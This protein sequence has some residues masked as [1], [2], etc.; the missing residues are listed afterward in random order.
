MTTPGLIRAREAY[1]RRAWRE[2][3]AAYSEERAAGTFAFTDYEN[4]GTTAHLIGD[5]ELS[6]E[7]LAEGYR[8]GMRRG[9]PTWAARMAFWIGHGLI[10]DGGMSQAAG[11]FARGKQ[12][13]A[14]R[15][16]DCAE[17]G[18]L[19]IPDGVGL[20]ESGEPEAAVQ[21]FRDILALA[22]AVD[23]PQLRTMATFGLG[24]ATLRLGDIEGGMSVL[25]EVIVAISLGEMPAM[26]I[27][28]AYCGVLEA[29]HEVLDLGRARE[30]TGALTAW[31]EEQPDLVPYR[32]PCRVYRAEVL[33][34]DGAWSE[35]F[36][37]A[38]QA[39]DWLQEL[40]T[41]EGPGD[42][43][44]RLGE[45]H[46]LRAGMAAAEEYYRQASRAGRRPEP[47]NSLLLL[48][49][50]KTEQA[51]SSIRRAIREET[52]AAAPRA[53]LLDAALRIADAMGDPEEAHRLADEIQKVAGTQKTVAL[54]GIADRALGLALMLGGEAEAA[55]APL[56]RAW[57]DW[58]R[59]G[60]P[61]EAGYTR[62]LLGRAY[63]SLGDT[64]AAAMEFDAARWVFTEL[65]ALHD[66]AELDRLAGE[67]AGALPTGPL[68][69]R[70]REVLALIAQGRTNKEIGARLVIS[71]HTVARHV[72]NMLGKLGL[73][74]RT[75][76]ATYA[77][78]SGL[79]PARTPQS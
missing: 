8:E 2:A 36:A 29:C 58:Q 24:R 35:A 69:L 42:A 51:V 3:H 34:F 54:R 79:I 19:R 53:L 72:Q 45:I 44:Y 49:Q 40:R 28:D 37:E 78:E 27:G 4:Y 73:A 66:L 64:D 41:P 63:Q 55:I 38:Q 30:W 47:G 65:G 33:Q 12:L 59:L 16:G 7:I 74:S 9:E 32:E 62:V 13:L 5:N 56:R 14:G 22:T 48:A 76:L 60:V 43:F 15:E 67:R 1:A 68:T 25:D 10:F 71:E 77:V 23:D 75:A 46:R 70:E 11:W 17:A 6:R 21:V 57:A 50:G 61:Y 39:C 20:I 26:V 18:F 52:G 31:C